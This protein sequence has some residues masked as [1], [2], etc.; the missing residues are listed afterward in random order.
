MAV[1]GTD[2]VWIVGP[3][4]HVLVVEG[5]AGDVLALRGFG[6]AVRCLYQS[7]GVNSRGVH[8]DA[9]HGLGPVCSS[10]RPCCRIPVLDGV[11]VVATPMVG[12]EGSLQGAW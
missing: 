8:V 5:F 1:A 11:R 4:E 3:I 9:G 10:F 12:G 2:G 6:F 7:A